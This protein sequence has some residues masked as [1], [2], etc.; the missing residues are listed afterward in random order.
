M[1]TSNTNVVIS[2]LKGIDWASAIKQGWVWMSEN[3]DFVFLALLKVVSLLS[4]VAGI[5]YMV[6]FMSQVFLAMLG[7]ILVSVVVFMYMGSICFDSESKYLCY[8]SLGSLLN[9][10]SNAT[11]VS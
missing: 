8:F 10:T 3:Y 2:F 1:T 5:A 7:N 9:H 4:V 6:K 11:L